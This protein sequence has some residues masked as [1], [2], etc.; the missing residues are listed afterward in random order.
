ML[1]KTACK[2]PCIKLSIS[3]L[4]GEY[5]I[6]IK[7]TNLADWGK[8]IFPV[9][10]DSY[11]IKNITESQGFMAGWSTSKT[12]DPDLQPPGEEGDLKKWLEC[13]VYN[14]FDGYC[15]GYKKF[16]LINCRENMSK[17]SNKDNKMITSFTK[18]WIYFSTIRKNELSYDSLCRVKYNLS[19][20]LYP[21]FCHGGASGVYLLTELDFEIL[22]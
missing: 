10:I 17:W 19:K 14:S 3:T 8:L 4:R 18:D 2:S 1:I 21:T 6:L 5:G 20:A 11:S 15:Y 22:N 7:R 16:D 13:V 9:I 12:L